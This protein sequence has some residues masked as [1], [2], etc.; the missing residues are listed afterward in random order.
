M[1]KE[2]KY[3]SFIEE[4]LSFASRQ[5]FV[6]DVKE[7]FG[8]LWVG[9]YDVDGESLT[10]GEYAGLPACEMIRFGRGVCGTAWKEKRT[11]IVPDVE[12]FSGHIACSSLSKSEIVIPIFDGENVVSELDIDSE[13]L[14]TFDEVDARYLS[15]LLGNI[16]KD[17]TKNK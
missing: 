8:F 4:H 2:Q 16:L 6:E 13:E 15:L 3:Q 7:Y 14:G 17:N 9:F 11:I 12:Q 1:T 5:E 10:L